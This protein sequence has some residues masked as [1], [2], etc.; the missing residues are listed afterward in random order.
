[1]TEVLNVWSIANFIL[2]WRIYW[3]G[4]FLPNWWVCHICPERDRQPNLRTFSDT[5]KLFWIKLKSRQWPDLFLFPS[6]VLDGA[7]I[8][9]LATELDKKK[10]HCITCT[11]QLYLKYVHIVIV[12]PGVF[13]KPE[14]FSRT[15]QRVNV[16]ISW[17]IFCWD[18]AGL[19]IWKM[20]IPDSSKLYFVGLFIIRF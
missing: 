4:F 15:L 1:M 2:R 3:I 14:I 18:I 9:D 13:F 12:G 20:E 5:K 16:R 10:Y 8:H 11:V 17:C 6:K 7:L 19:V